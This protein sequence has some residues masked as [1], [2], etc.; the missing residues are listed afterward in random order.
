M[1]ASGTA[2]PTSLPE[3]FGIGGPTQAENAS[4]MAHAIA[5]STAGGGRHKFA[6]RN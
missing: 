4:D 3:T 1:P 6:L 2:P 5:R